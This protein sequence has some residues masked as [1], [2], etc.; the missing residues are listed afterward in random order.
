MPDCSCAILLRPTK[1][2][3]LYIQQSMRPMRYQPGKR[4]VILDHVG[5]YARF[6]LPDA[7][8]E[9]TLDPNHTKKQDK[10]PP[11]RQCPKCFATFEPQAVCPICGYIFPVQSR[12]IEEI[13]ETAMQK[14][15]GFVLNYDSPRQC[16]SYQELQAYGRRKGY[17]PGWSYIMGKRMGFI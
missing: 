13:R 5:N 6:G 9:W 2:L 8:R 15:E 7:D 16:K 12:T 14:I 10:A 4:A 3:T 17:K 11:V 1:S